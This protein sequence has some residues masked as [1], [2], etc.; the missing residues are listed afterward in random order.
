MNAY[1]AIEDIAAELHIAV[2][3]AN[4]DKLTR[5]AEAAALEIDG[6]IDAA[7][8]PDYSPPWNPVYESVNIAR[9]CEVFKTG[10]SLFGVVGYDQTGALRAPRDGFARYRADLLPYKQQF[11]IA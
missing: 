5:C 8:P 11:G 6:W 1:C 2:T 10:D 3:A 7:S 4:T 9:A